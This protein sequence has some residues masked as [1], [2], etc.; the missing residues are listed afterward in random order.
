[1]PGMSRITDLI[2]AMGGAGAV[3]NAAV[4][5]QERRDEEA[6][7]QARLER[8]SVPAPTQPATAA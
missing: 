8:I 5:C 6:V 7:L 4:A 3:A 1:M 2:H